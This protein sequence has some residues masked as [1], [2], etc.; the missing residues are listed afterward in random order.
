MKRQFITL[1]Y[2]VLTILSF[3]NTSPLEAA[4]KKKKLQYAVIS[5]SY[6]VGMFSHFFTVLG[7]LDYYDK[8][9]FAGVKIDFGRQ[10]LYYDKEW[11]PNW[12]GYYFEPIEVGNMKNGEQKTFRRRECIF[13]SYRATS[14]ISRQRAYEL[15]Q[16][17]VKVKPE[18]ASEIDQFVNEYFTAPFVIGVHYRGTD[19]IT[20]GEAGFV[21]YD[22]IIQKVV[23]VV[24][25][26]DLT[27]YKVYVATDETNFLNYIQRHF[28]EQVV[29]QEAT[30]SSTKTPIHLKSKNPYQIGKEA[31]IDALL[32]SKCDYLIRTSSNLSQASTY[33]NPKMPVDWVTK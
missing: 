23:E 22:T 2:F 19:K 28:P 20:T 13:Q 14:L 24:K 18:I 6:S 4:Y 30:R 21:S 10:G 32:L 7:F 25:E 15:I 1:C 33:F 5:P 12:W 16:K 17:Y 27:D 29:Y 26:Y 8:E 31:V 3:T 9:R 11:G